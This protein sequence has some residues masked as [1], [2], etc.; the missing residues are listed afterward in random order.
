[1]GG[2]TQSCSA[3][4][5]STIESPIDSPDVVSIHP[6]SILF[7]MPTINDALPEFESLT[8]TCL[9]MHED[10]WRQLEFISKDQ[11][12]LIDMEM[13]RIKAIYENHMVDSSLGFNNIAVRKMITAPVSI[14]LRNFKN[15]LISH[16][17]KM[18]GLTLDNNE[19]QV[20]DGIYFDS[21]GVGYYGIVKGDIVTTLGIDYVKGEKELIAASKKMSKF[22]AKENLYLIDW[23][24]MNIYDERNVESDLLKN[25]R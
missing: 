15:I 6:N 7:S 14:A 18:Q 23:K 20:K 2:I 17:T 24:Y 22:L 10:D 19:G 25:V 5:E 12:P 3:K 16:G 8:D 9:S 11:R 13:V 4:R 21:D 1:M